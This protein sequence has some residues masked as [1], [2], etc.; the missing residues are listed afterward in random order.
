MTYLLDTNVL[1]ALM[2]GEPKVVARLREVGRDAVSV[3]QPA[4]AEIAYGL[5]RLPASKRRTT[6]LTRFEVL[7]RELP[8]A[9]WTDEVSATFGA[10]KAALHRKGTPIE[11]FDVAIAAHALAVDGTAVTANG[12]HFSRIA[13]LKVEDWER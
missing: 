7:R 1:S 8:R 11:D 10:I 3:P 4:F 12:K 2:R 5:E 9:A 13:R 6:L